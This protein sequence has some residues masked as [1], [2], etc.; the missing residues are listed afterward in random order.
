MQH[1]RQL[2]FRRQFLDSNGIIPRQHD[3]VFHRVLQ[4]TD[5]SRPRIIQQLLKRFGCYRRLWFS[6]LGGEALR[7][8]ANER[9]NI[10]LP[11]AERRDFNLEGIN[12]VIQIGA[13]PVFRQRLR[14]RAIGGGDDTKICFLHA[15]AAERPILPF[16][17]DP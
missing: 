1:R 10:F 2:N 3:R 7:E 4:F 17:Q 11:F 9:W 5:I 8:S 6:Q 16:L 15:R 14:N 12:S 13:Q